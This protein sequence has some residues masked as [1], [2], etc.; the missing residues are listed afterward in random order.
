MLHSVTYMHL[1][2]TTLKGATSCFIG[3]G[4]LKNKD[5]YDT[6]NPVPTSL[7]VTRASNKT[8][9]T[10]SIPI[11]ASSYTSMNCGSKWWVTFANRGKKKHDYF[12]PPQA[13]VP[14]PHLQAQLHIQ[15]FEM[16]GPIQ[17]QAC[18]GHSPLW[19]HKQMIWMG[20]V[21][22]WPYLTRDHKE[23]LAL[24]QNH[25]YPSICVP[26]LQLSSKQHLM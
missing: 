3:I 18:C 4:N 11:H 23:P 16:E 7:V 21:H 19:R 9:T 14:A 2:S 20:R 22:A 12:I 8:P 25:W 10:S 17:G 13:P 15:V 1:L 26:C 5:N 24:H 6:S